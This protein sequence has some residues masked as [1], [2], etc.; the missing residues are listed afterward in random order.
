L[1]TDVSVS[2]NKDETARRQAQWPAA[3][4][5]VVAGDRIKKSRKICEKRGGGLTLRPPIWRAL[6][7]GAACRD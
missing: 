6:I 3:A 1:A 7:C 2:T 4:K 5:R